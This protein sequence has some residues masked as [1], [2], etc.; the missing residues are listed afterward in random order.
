MRW[1]S[2]LCL[3]FTAAMLAAQSAVAQPLEA[4]AVARAAA[5]AV[6]SSVNAGTVETLTVDEGG[7]FRQG[8]V[9]ARLD[10]ALHEAELASLR[11][12]HDAAL[13]RS[14][15]L[16]Q[17]LARG[18]AGHAEVA[19]A[20][21]I[22]VAAG[23]KANKAEVMVRG[24]TILA[25][26]DGRIA[27]YSVNAFEYVETSQPVL[28]IVS[29]GKPDLE[30]IAPDTW[31]SWIVPGQAGKVQFEAMAGT[32]DIVVTGIAPVVDPVSQTVKLSAGFDSAAG[33][34]LPGMSG[35]ARFE[36]GQ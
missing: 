27:E 22:A 17:L 12:E 10:C 4:P 6:I 15:A 30:I 23:A 8:D 9:L 5:E 3:A 33:G 25:P 13:I 1:K 11:A 34:V 28:S 20:K 26:F 14:R 36:T 24:C 2:Q 35:R 32:F 7:E 16:D 18:S 21:A 29:S 31:L 19:A